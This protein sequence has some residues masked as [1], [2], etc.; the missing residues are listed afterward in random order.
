MSDEQGS[1]RLC[2]GPLMHRFDGRL[3]GRHAVRYFECTACGSLQTE[4]PHCLDEAY[5]D[6]NLSRL[7]T[8]AAQRNLDNLGAVLLLSRVLGLRRAV[9]HGGSDGL[10]TRLLRD[11]GVDVQVL[12]RHATP[13]YAAGFDRPAGLRPDLVLAFEVLEHLPHPAEDLRP[14]FDLQAPVLLVSTDAW[15]GQGPDWWY[16]AP[17]SGQHVFFYSRRALAQIAAREGYRLARSGGYW[18]FLRQGAFARWRELLA[19]RLLTGGLRRLRNAW[20]VTRPTPG[21]WRDHEMLA[22]EGRNAARPQ[23][24]TGPT[25]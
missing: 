16:L 22:A 18:L 20:A 12:D 10:L 9:D 19:A 25:L 21:I 24:A 1:C 8:G 7:D 6:G 3:L 2:A 11:R 15:A 17:D 4:T 13:R 23:S 14:L 5:A